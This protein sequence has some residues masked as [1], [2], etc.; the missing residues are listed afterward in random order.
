MR[1]LNQKLLRIAMAA[2]LAAGLA[3]RTQATE[4]ESNDPEP[5]DPAVNL[6]VL[7]VGINHYEAQETVDEGFQR[8]SVIEFAN[9]KY[10]AQDVIAI[11]DA[12]LSHGLSPNQLHL[13]ADMAGAEGCETPTY[14]GVMDRIASLQTTPDQTLLVMFCGHGINIGADSYLCFPETRIDGNVE[15]GNLYAENALSV[16]ELSEAMAAKDANYKI[17][18]TDACRN[19]SSDVA[20]YGVSGSIQ[21]Y[22]LSSHIDNMSSFEGVGN[23]VMIVS[24]CLPSEVSLE[25]DQ[26]GHGLFASHLIDA[27]EGRA[28]FEGPGNRDGQLSLYEVFNYASNKTTESSEREF[29]PRQRP[30]CEGGFTAEC[31]LLALNEEIRSELATRYQEGEFFV[32]PLGFKQ[33]LSV[34]KYEN[35]MD[36]LYVGD[37]DLA[38]QLCS[39]V[40]ETLPGHQHALRLRSISY[41][42]QGQFVEAFDDTKQL[43]SKL[44][45]R[46]SGSQ[47]LASIR[48]LTQFQQKLRDLRPGDLIEVD[49]VSKEAGETQRGKYLRVCSIK[50]AGDSDWQAVEGWVEA[51]QLIPASP[52]AQLEMLRSYQ[53]AANQPV[54]DMAG[55]NV[56]INRM[57]YSPYIQNGGNI[58]EAIQR[59]NEVQGVINQYNS[60][61]YAPSIPSLPSIPYSGF[62][63]F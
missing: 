54:T 39:E 61:P 55:E 10:A 14:A 3:A 18:V 31:K 19:Y 45:I 8:P 46:Y 2:M 51:S 53:Y 47:Q 21:R 7:L 29:G 30:F 59:Y 63:P 25:V 23:Q 16:G 60:I 17:I 13:F 37:T 1:Q 56:A 50:P 20:A 58:G 34:S 48:H 4:F 43:E 40:L 9:L 42:T 52:E 12:L 49:N 27:L 41:A 6:Q 24:S 44:K 28:D 11:R 33:Q 36:A 15:T 38:I 35:A 5:S 32:A 26:R 62:L 22:N 57:T